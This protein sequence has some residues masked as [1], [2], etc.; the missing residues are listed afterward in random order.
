MRLTRIIALAVAAI[1]TAGTLALAGT[2]VQ[3]ARPPSRASQASRV[4]PT[5]YPPQPP[6]LTVSDATLAVGETF[7]LTGAG[8]SP[9]RGRPAGF[10]LP[11]ALHAGP[12]RG[13]GPAGQRRGRG[14]AAPVARSLP[15][16]ADPANPTI[17]RA[18]AAGAFSIRLRFDRQGE[19]VITATG[20]VSGLT[21]SVTVTVITTAAGVAVASDR[22]QH[23]PADRRGLRFG[24]YRRA[25]G[26]A[27][28]HLASAYPS[29]RCRCVRGSV[30]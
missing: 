25:A 28:D 10:H 24:G 5:P 19:V 26:A 16:R 9:D 15:E 21:G 18:D 12:G 20:L 1:A 2:P 14:D 29:C 11:A 13:P 8:F 3:A 4:E 7:T 17:V 30:G 6:T 22:Q 27:G 23:R